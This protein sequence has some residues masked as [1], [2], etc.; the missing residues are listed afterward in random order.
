MVFLDERKKIILK[1]IIDDY[2]N[3]AEPVGSRTVS[4]RREI[5]LS[6]AT[7]R[8]EMADLE[9]MGFLEQPHTSAG[10]VPS[11]KGYRFYVDELMVKRE[12]TSTEIG[13][14]EDSLN[15]KINE[16]GQ[17]IRQASAVISDITKYTSMAVTPRMNKATLKHVQIIVLEYDKLLVVLVTGAGIVKNSFVR[18]RKSIDRKG[19]ETI[20]NFINEK[21]SGVLLEKIDLDDLIERAKDEI[22]AINTDVFLTIVSALSDCLNQVFYSE[23]FVEGVTKIFNFPEFQDLFRAQQFLNFL[24]TK[25]FLNI[26]HMDEGRK[27]GVV[28]KIGMENESEEVK[29]CS[30]LTVTYS[31]DK[32]VLGS[33]GVIGPTRMQYP[34]VISSLDHIRRVINKELDKII[35]ENSDM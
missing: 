35:S 16:L 22:K 32:E 14:I 33:I 27:N 30:I 13:S 1:A 12:L 11:D 34:I 31:L 8:N 24:N 25:D 4:R 7:V 10:R 26:A 29:D 23:I 3:T 28:I 5:G 15:V 6:S 18:L 21:L 20:S 19:L 9:E 2:I 17:L